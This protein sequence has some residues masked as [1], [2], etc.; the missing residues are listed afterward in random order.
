M[1]G[2]KFGAIKVEIDGHVFDSKAEARRYG[3]L[4]L[5]QRARQIQNLELQPK[6]PIVINGVKI[7]TYIA[8]F[9]YLER[10]KRV[11]E[12]IKSEPTK[13]AVYRIKVKLMEAVYPDTK[14]TEI[15]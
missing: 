6:F 3:E 5:L 10:D 11:V 8:D 12:D 13:T 7:C 1:R 14:I 9:A 15:M 4:R 2:N